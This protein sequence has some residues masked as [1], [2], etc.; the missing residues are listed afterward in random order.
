MGSYIVCNAEFLFSV[1]LT[2]HYVFINVSSK[3][4][5]NIFGQTPNKTDYSLLELKEAIN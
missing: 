4:T 2:I 5:L 3:P 1:A